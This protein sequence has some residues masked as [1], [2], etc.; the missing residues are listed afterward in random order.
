MDFSR[1]PAMKALASSFP[2][3]V[4][5]AHSIDEDELLRLTPAGAAARFL[6]AARER[7]IRYLYVHMFPGL[8][9]GENGRYVL[10]LAALLRDNG[11]EIGLAIPRW[12]SAP[13]GWP[14][15]VKLRQLLA[16]L[17][18]V[19]GPWWIFRRWGDRPLLLGPLALGAALV[20]AALLSSREFMLGLA[21]FRGVK[22]AMALPFLLVAGDMYS[23]DEVKGF[24]R[25]PLSVG[26]A[27]GL[28]LVALAAI[29]CLMRSGNESA[30]VASAG[31]LRVRDGLETLL[32]VRPRFKEFAV[33]WPLLWLG[34]R[35]RARGERL[36]GVDGRAFLLAGFIAPVSIVNTFCHAHVP[37]AVSLLRVFHGFWLGGLAGILPV[38]L[39]GTLLRSFVE[40][41][42]AGARQGVGG[43]MPKIPD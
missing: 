8:S 36:R 23:Q 35:M 15:P 22:A 20:V 11:F 40:R 41:P 25:R 37:L 28:S 12:S 10:K 29:V 38:V 27:V 16:F 39:Q 4:V 2:D 3:R 42:P 14:G 30:L 33:G 34:S 26:T 31:E 9:S 19:L 32:G 5:R 18:A 24:L 13:K 21:E 7:G 43:V 6:R 1:E 17:A